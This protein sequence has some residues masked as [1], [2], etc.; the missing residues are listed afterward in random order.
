MSQE[1][2]HISGWKWMLLTLL[3]LISFVRIFNKCSFSYDKASSDPYEQWSGH[4]IPP[5]AY[6]ES[7]RHNNFEMTYPTHHALSRRSAD[8]LTMEKW[9]KV[10]KDTLI[11]VDMTSKLK[12]PA[13]WFVQKPIDEKVR[14][15]FITPKNI[16]ITFYTFSTDKNL[17]S[18]LYD[19]RDYNFKPEGIENH[20][21]DVKEVKYTFRHHNIEY[22]GAALG[23]KEKNMMSIFTF[24]GK[25]YSSKELEN[26]LIKF[27]A[28]NIIEV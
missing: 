22:R 6:A 19:L 27:L 11:R 4:V 23:L 17:V 3:T 24:E 8:S 1:S 5:K 25:D 12:I 16:Q 26:F 10:E 14:F 2:Q 28:R 13:H 7:I 9:V 18:C 21:E 15:V 20:A